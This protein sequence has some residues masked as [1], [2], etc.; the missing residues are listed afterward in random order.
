MWI[1]GLIISKKFRFIDIL[2][3]MTLAKFPYI[4]LAIIGFFVEIPDMSNLMHDPYSVFQSVPFD[5]L[6]ALSLP[7]TI[8]YIILIY[9]AFR[10]SCDISGSKLTVGL[11]VGL[12]VA[13]ILSKIF[14][15]L[16]V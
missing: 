14:T 2:G 3:T 11:I 10:V 12:L 4:I 15:Y 9:N 7:V 13:E 6:L 8:W 16:L 1:T 5:I